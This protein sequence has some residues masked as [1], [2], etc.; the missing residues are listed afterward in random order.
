MAIDCEADLIQGSSNKLV[1]QVA[2]MKDINVEG[3][4]GA[5]ECMPDAK[6][7]AGYGL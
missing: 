1:K 6:V 2:S 7:L 5:K 4:G 3:T